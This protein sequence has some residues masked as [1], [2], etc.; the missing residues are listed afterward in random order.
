MRPR[1]E[2]AGLVLVG[3]D[4]G[5]QVT[6]QDTPSVTIGKTTDPQATKEGRSVQEKQ[7]TGTPLLPKA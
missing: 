1:S 2:L 7:E 4:Q 5:V 6:G 3:L